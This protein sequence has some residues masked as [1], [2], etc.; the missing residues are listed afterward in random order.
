M[1]KNIFSKEGIGNLELLTNYKVHNYDTNKF[2]N[3]LINDFNF[4]SNDKVFKNLFNNKILANVKNINYESKNVN[5]YKEEPTSEIFGSIGLLTELNFIK[6]KDGFNH[7]F[8]P[9]TLISSGSMRQET[10][11]SRLTP[12]SAFSMNRISNINN[13]ETGLS[14]TIGF[15]YKI[16]N[17]DTTKFDFH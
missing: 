13:F 9:K 12:G 3:F 4:E 7:L 15:D 14:G 5:I 6:L 10:D 2:T 1:D 17:N 8:K 16:K 11:G